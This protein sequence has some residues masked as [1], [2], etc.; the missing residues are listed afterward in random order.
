MTETARARHLAAAGAPL[1]RA[2]DRA[3]A[4]RAIPGNDVTHLADGPRTMEAILALIDGARD[5][6][7]F[8]NYIIRSDGAGERAADALIAAAR[9]G[10]TVRV[11][12]DALG[13]RWTRRAYWRRLTTGGVAVRRFH[14]INPFRPI[15]TL[16]RDHRKYVAADGRRAI[17]GGMCIGDEWVGRPDDGGEA[18]R[19][20]AVEV[21]GPAVT[22][23]DLTFLRRWTQTGADGTETTV[24]TPAEA[25]GAAQVRVIDGIPGRLRLVRAVELL[26]A[27]A[28]ERLWLT[29]A[30]LIPPISLYAT[31]ISAARDGV[32]VRILVPGRTD[33]P[34]V[35]AL[36]R[37][38]YRELLAAG[39]RIWEWH[40]PMLH[41]K[42]VLVDDR[43]FKVG[44]SNL[45]PSSLI[46]NYEID[47]LVDD[48]PTAD[49]AA[50][51]FRR[52]LA[53]AVE[54]VLR[55]RQAPRRLAD[56]LPPAVV[57]ETRG[58]PP[59]R[60]SRDLPERAVLQ[61]RQVAGGARRSIAGTI[62]FALVGWGV[63]L[64]TLPRIMAYF[65]AAVAFLLAGG[66][67]WHVFVRWRH[68][69]R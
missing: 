6:V 11:L 29:D 62:L 40:G 17:V 27:S 8:E 49:A 51:Q 45:N 22:A 68:R 65:L 15:R 47:L 41:A 32:D 37:A 4:A 5:T 21:C 36:T 13:C 14:P 9:R 69:D 25:C 38:G 39:V 19:D 42:T 57:P 61:V 23:L 28:A 2:L 31:L 64:L 56:R 1:D 53:D 3:C 43:W 52:D 12:Y 20:T 30:Y 60:A 58:R 46:S 34:V 26:A 24:S 7:H 33:L 16:R 50:R 48:V 59:R 55:P 54:I 35:R 44:S 18:W 10:A 66:G 67:A 63:L